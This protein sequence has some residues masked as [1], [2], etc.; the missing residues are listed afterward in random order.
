MIVLAVVHAATGLTFDPVIPIS[1]TVSVVL[2][3]INM[4]LAIWVTVFSARSIPRT[5]LPFQKIR[6]LGLALLALSLAWGTA[7]RLNVP[8]TAATVAFTVALVISTVGTLGFL[9]RTGVHHP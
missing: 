6:F 3:S 8:A 7:A 9:R 4:V 5:P 2:R 1:D